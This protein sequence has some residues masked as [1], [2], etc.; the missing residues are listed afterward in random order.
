MHYK[1]PNLKFDLVGVDKFLTV[2]GKENLE[3]A[4]K[5]SVSKERLPEEPEVVILEVIKML[6]WNQ[7]KNTTGYGQNHSASFFFKFSIT[8]TG[9][10]STLFCNA[11]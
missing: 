7:E 9:V 2:M 10:G 6:L 4:S 3:V 8:C 1:L 5:L 11:K